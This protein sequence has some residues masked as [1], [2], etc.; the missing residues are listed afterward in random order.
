MRG[1]YP[2]IK[3]C[4]LTD[5]DEALACADAGAD[6][7]GLVFYPPSPR[8]VSIEKAAEIVSALPA[9]IIRMIFLGR[10]IE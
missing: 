10:S 7:I 6:A 2:Q 4:G 3:I 9:F 1:C 8:L 5:P